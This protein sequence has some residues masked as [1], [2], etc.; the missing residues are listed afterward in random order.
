MNLSTYAA[1]A[2]LDGTAMPATLYVQLHTGNPGTAG[3]ANVAADNRRRSF[4]RTAAA[5]G[6]CSNAALLEWLLA[7]ATEDLTHI[8]V[9]DANAAG[10]PWWIGPI[11][12]A[13]VG[14]VTG[15][16]TEIPVNQ[17]DLTFQRWT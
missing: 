13:P 11:T 1:N 16:T 8:S 4:T 17:L 5:L 7:T 9:W 3:T 12:G 2:I 6:T 14:A 10:N 15:Q